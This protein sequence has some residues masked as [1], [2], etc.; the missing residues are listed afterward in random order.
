LVCDNENNPISM[1]KDTSDLYEFTYDLRVFEERYNVL[2]I[3]S[4]RCGLLHAN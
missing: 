4:G 1:R 2:M 3:Q